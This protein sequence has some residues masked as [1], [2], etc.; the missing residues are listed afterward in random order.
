MGIDLL[1]VNFYLFYCSLCYMSK[2]Q[3]LYVFVT[4]TKQVAYK[5]DKGLLCSSSVQF[6]I[7]SVTCI[8]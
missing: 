6:A 8:I 2:L 3:W 7:V 4:P 1:S 5:H